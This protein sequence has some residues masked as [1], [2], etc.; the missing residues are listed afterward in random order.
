M[1]KRD[2]EALVWS[3]L[4]VLKAEIVLKVLE[5]VL[6]MT[7]VV[8]GV[9]CVLWVL[10]ELEVAEVLRC[11]L[12]CLLEVLEMPEAMRCILLCMLDMLDMMRCVLLCLMEV[13]EVS[14]LMQCVR[15]YLLEI[16][17][18]AEAMHGVWR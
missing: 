16:V 18:V 13:M 14:E 11:V 7:E 6:Y 3:L 17:E 5:V 8:N 9:R 15:L 4:D 1:L 12:L 10:E 2:K